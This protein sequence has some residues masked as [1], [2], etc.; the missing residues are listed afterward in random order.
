M[1][2]IKILI[3]AFVQLHCFLRSFFPCHSSFQLFHLVFLQAFLQKI[4]YEGACENHLGETFLPGLVW[5]NPSARHAIHLASR[6]TL[7][8]FLCTVNPL[9]LILGT[10]CSK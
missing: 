5:C 1:Y 7:T 4:Y 9:M 6:L 8:S 3:Q 10:L 2:Y